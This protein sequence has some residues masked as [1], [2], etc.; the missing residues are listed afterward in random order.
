MRI[1]GPENFEKIIKK[2]IFP[3]SY[4][5]GSE[6]F[7]DRELPERKYFF[8]DLQ[9]KELPEEDYQKAQEVWRIF[10]IENF[11][12]WHDLYLFR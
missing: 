5:T 3:Y 4:F 10:Q 11:A 9:Q 2:G 12:E 7:A 8:N 6:V 1:V